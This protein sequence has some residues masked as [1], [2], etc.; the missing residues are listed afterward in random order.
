MM[1]QARTG[2]CWCLF[3]KTLVINIFFGGMIA[4]SLF[5][6]AQIPAAENSN[7][8]DKAKIT[9]DSD[10]NLPFAIIKLGSSLYGFD[11][12]L[13][14]GSSALQVSKP[15][16][17]VARDN[18]TFVNLWKKYIEPDYVEDEINPFGD[19]VAV[20]IFRGR[21]SCDGY[22]VKVDR[23]HWSDRY[24]EARTIE[25]KVTF[26][27]PFVDYSQP[28]KLC[29]PCAVIVLDKQLVDRI[30]F[31]KKSIE[32]MATHISYERLTID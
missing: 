19:R 12:L 2:G 15:K 20:F 28:R 30:L 3:C 5:G 10:D 26:E 31:T 6:V 9:V 27:N 11:E 7:V 32:V 21:Q 13:E 22:S 24:R 8:M 14:S 25:I 4:L 29:S 23:V 18:T 1:P 17:F 16:I